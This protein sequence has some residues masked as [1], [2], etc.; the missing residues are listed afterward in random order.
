MSII[1]RKLAGV[2][3]E[4]KEI[5]PKN[6]IKNRIED[7]KKNIKNELQISKLEEDKNNKKDDL[8]DQNNNSNINILNLS[9]INQREYIIDKK[10]DKKLYKDYSKNDKNKLSLK[11]EIPKITPKKKGLFS[12]SIKINESFSF[13][14]NL[15]PDKPKNKYNKHKMKYIFPYYYFFLDF[16]FD[17][18]LHPEKFLCLPKTYFIVYN[19]MCQIYDISSHII[20]FKQ[21]NS[22]KKIF[23]ENQHES[24]DEIRSIRKIHKINIK[25][26]KS[27][28]Q[29]DKDLKLK[30]SVI[31]PNDLF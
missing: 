20:L 15:Q 3:F 2:F 11:E 1:K 29:L 27:I 23:E 12:S 25:H 22:L 21:V 19:Y 7:I 28:E 26:R 9:K 31:F 13:Y 30:R 5:R 18:I 14:E 16:I 4:C 24:E 6:N 10:I 8:I 17:K